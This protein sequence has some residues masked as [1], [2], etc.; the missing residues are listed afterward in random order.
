MGFLQ[1]CTTLASHASK[2]H[3]HRGCLSS[4]SLATIVIYL[5]SPLVCVICVIILAVIVYLAL[6]DAPCP[7]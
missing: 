5:Q 4:D 2:Y 6:H 1:E 3:R 7:R